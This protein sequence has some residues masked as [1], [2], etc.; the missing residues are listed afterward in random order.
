[1]SRV[2]HRTWQKHQ[3]RAGGRDTAIPATATD[4]GYTDERDDQLQETASKCGR[5]RW[6]GVTIVPTKGANEFA[7]AELKID[8]SRSGFAEVLVRSNNELALKECT[9]TALKLA[10]ATVKT[11]AS[12]LY[13][14]QSNVG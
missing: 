10:G 7:I 8:V 1:M 14:S 3:H 12:A 6:I 2:L 5:D 13:D 9:A 11:E 4:N